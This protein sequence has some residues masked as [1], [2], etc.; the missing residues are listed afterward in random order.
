MISCRA[1]EGVSECG[2]LF[3]TV[4]EALQVGQMDPQGPSPPGAQR[5]V[6]AGGAFSAGPSMA[7]AEFAR[8]LLS[9]P[10]SQHALRSGHHQLRCP[11]GSV[12]PRL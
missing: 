7:I 8:G 10:S 1:L 11:L 12:Q 4:C 2:R 9:R 5:K 6:T 3:I